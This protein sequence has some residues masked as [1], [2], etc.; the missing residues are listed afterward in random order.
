MEERRVYKPDFTLNLNGEDVYLEYFGLSNYNQSYDNLRIKKENYHR[1]HK[2]KFI[3]LNYQ[4]DDE[5]LKMLKEELIKLGFVLNP[6]SY[7][8][9]YDAMLSSN[10]T[11]QFYPFR[12][13]MFHIISVLKSS[14][15]RDDISLV[16]NEY[17]DTLLEDERFLAE[18][19]F[20]YIKEF[21]LYYQKRLFGSVDYGF[22]FSDMIY[23]ANKYIDNV[24][25]DNKLN[26]DY[27]IIDEYQDISQDR[28][29]FTRNMIN[30]TNA[31]VVAV[32]DDWQSIFGFTGSKIDYIY[33]F[34]E[35]FNGVKKFKISHTYRN[36]QELV[37]YSGSFIMKNVKQIEKDLVSD[38]HVEMP[39]RFVMFDEDNEYEE[40]KKLILNIHS[41]NPEHSIMIL[42]RNNKF[43]DEMYD[44]ELRDDIGSKITFVGYDDILIE[45]MT[46]HK[47]KGLA[48]DEVILIGLDNRF[49]SS[50]S[51]G[52]WFESLFRMIPDEEP[53]EFPEERRIFYVALTRTKN[54]VYL[55]VNK[56]PK[57]R[58]PFVNEIYQIILDNNNK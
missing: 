4:K 31:K 32:G 45:G 15:K 36:S 16:V 11:S 57:L 53:I 44:D 38:K 2:N 3:S 33:N 5:L 10:P 55:L 20:Y 54:Y 12:D 41:N 8:D 37:D 19:Q 46:I 43:I 21:Y 18:R 30:R 1:E 58:S 26:F 9:I 52:F 28:Y 17:F 29:E 23:Y 7:R 22:D 39:I 34:D 25:I 47:S 50:H 27:L 14:A 42:A 35:Y 48:S 51:G 56:N 40:L 24:G 6:K 13:F 49:P